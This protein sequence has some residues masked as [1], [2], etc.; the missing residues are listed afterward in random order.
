[1]LAATHTRHAPW[2]VVSF[3]DQR[4]GRLTVIR[5]LLDKLPDI[6]FEPEPIELVPLPGPLADEEY[7]VVKPLAPFRG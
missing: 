2:T 6:A 5:D 4:E 1:M 3:N 7:S